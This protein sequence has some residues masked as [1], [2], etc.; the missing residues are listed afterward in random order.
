MSKEEIVKCVLI[1]I[2]CKK[3]DPVDVKCGG[4]AYLGFDFWVKDSEKEEMKS[5]IIESLKDFNIPIASI[6]YNGEDD[7]PLRSI[8]TKEMILEEIDSEA[9]YL[10]E[11]PNYL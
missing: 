7:R 9:I 5:Y 6:Y 11:R 4:P 8:W 2:D 1:S 3:N 10:Q